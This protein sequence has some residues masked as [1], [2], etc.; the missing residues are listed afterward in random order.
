MLT[1]CHRNVDPLLVGELDDRGAEAPHG[2]PHGALSDCPSLV[3]SATAS[4]STTRVDVLAVWDAEERIT[5]RTP[6]QAHRDALNHREGPQRGGVTLH[7]RRDPL[8]IRHA[9]DDPLSK[10]LRGTTPVAIPELLGLFA[11]FEHLSLTELQAAFTACEARF[12]AGV[13]APENAGKPIKDAPDYLGTD[14][15]GQLARSY[16]M[17]AE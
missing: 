17:W 5:H 10:K 2:S 9:S 7:R 6:H 15:V 14:R 13:E 3:A 12:R 11:Q 1:P 8:R 16:G 4:P